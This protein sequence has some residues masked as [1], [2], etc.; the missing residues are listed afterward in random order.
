MYQNLQCESQAHSQALPKA[1]E[2]GEAV[3]AFAL[4]ACAEHAAMELKQL[5]LASI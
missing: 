1:S 4:E 3:L 5:A 2:V